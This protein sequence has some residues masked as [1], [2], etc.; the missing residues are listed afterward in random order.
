MNFLA[1]L[2]LSEPTP[3]A[4]LGNFLGDFVTGDPSDRYSEEITKG[5]H[6]HRRV[7]AF[8]DSHD[9]WRA[10]KARLSDERRRFAGV[11]VDIF[12]DYFLSKHWHKFC[13]LGLDKS[14]ESY[15]RDLVA[16]SD[17]VVEPVATDAI[18]YMT[19]ENWLERY[20]R[21]DGIAHSINRVALRSSRVAPIAG[22]IEELEAHEAELE[23]DFLA[24]Y[25]ALMEFV[26]KERI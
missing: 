11:I 14:I 15:Y 3:E 8:T 22:A 7:D 5:I 24:F 4:R 20:G 25:P 18:R 2:H 9:V 12:Y 19:E 26:G 1:H 17:A 21:K 23:L 10:S 6:V 13:R 16:V